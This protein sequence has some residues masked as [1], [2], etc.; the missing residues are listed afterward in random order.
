MFGDYER[1]DIVKNVEEIGW[2]VWN[3]VIY[4]LCEVVNLLFKVLFLEDDEFDFVG[5]MKELC[6][7]VFGS[8]VKELFVYFECEYV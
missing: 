1:K 3:M 7:E 8:R 6:I 5:V 4:D 2:F